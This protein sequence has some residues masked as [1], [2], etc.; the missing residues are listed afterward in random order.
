MDESKKNHAEQK[1]PCI[2]RVYNALFHIHENSKTTKLT[3]VGE[4]SQNSYLGKI[5]WK[6]LYIFFLD[7]GNYRLNIPYLKC[8]GPEVIQ[9]SIFFCFFLQHWRLNLGP[10]A[11]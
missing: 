8:L 3:Y 7:N 6:G 9:I 4:K 1:K 5:Y 2:K 11:C 10:Q